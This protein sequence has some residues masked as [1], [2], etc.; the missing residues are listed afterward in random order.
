MSLFSR[1]RAGSGGR[2]LVLLHGLGS[3][4][5]DL[6]A[7]AGELPDDLT[8][9]AHR[10]PHEYDPGYSWFDIRFEGD[11]RIFDESQ[12]LD[13]LAVLK[14]EIRTL[15]P[16]FERLVLAGFSQGAIMTFGVLATEPALIDGAGMLSGSIFP[17]F[18]EAARP[19]ESPT[20]PILIQHGQWDDVL[21]VAGARTLREALVRLGYTPIY[22][23]YPMGH[24]V[25]M[26]SLSDFGDWLA[27]V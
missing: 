21:P 9:I 11:R 18:A 1:R 25:S 4:E 16:D 13:S 24:G 15:R 12:A 8:V 14:K 7:F 27:T 10:A 19:A 22:R 20:F 6:L 2:A 17:A 3:D 5:N 26:D 23:E